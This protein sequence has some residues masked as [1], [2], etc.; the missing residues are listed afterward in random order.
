MVLF[1]PASTSSQPYA[2]LFCQLVYSFSVCS[3]LLFWL[4]L[5]LFSYISIRLII[6]S[7]CICESQPFRWIIF[8]WSESFVLLLQTNLFLSRK[9]PIYIC[10]HSHLGSGISLHRYCFV[11]T[12][13]YGQQFDDDQVCGFS[14]QDTCWA[15]GFH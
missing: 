14:P 9:N 8:T 6:S 4:S 11:P 10:I 5:A 13:F 1:L 12:T 3:V 7:N 15:I 2:M